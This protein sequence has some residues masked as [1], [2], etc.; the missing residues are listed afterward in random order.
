MATAELADRAEEVAKALFGEPNQRQSTKDELRFGTNGSLRVTI[1]GEHRGTWRDHETGNGGGVL[2]LIVHKQGGDRKSAAAWMREH[3]EGGAQPDRQI[4]ATYRYEDWAGELVHEVVRYA[5]KEFRQRRPDGR[6]GYQWNMKGVAPLLYNLPRV[7]DAVIGGEL[8][9]VVE[10]EKDADRLNA[11]G[12]VATC[13]AGG[14]G[15]W[16]PEHSRQIAGAR[17]AIIPDNDEAGRTHAEQVAVALR[18]GNHDVR[19]VEL[20]VDARKG[21]VSDW[22]DAGGTAAQL[23]ELIEVAPQWRPAFKPRFPLVWFG[24]EDARGP[25]KWLVR[26]LLVTSGLSVFFG[27]PKSTKTFVALDL[28]LH[29]AHG[30][31]W[32][33]MRVQRGG[34]A[35]I[36]GEGQAGV[37]QRMKAWRL[38]R[39]GEPSAPFALIP[40]SVNLFDDLDELDRLIADITGMAEPMGQPV[41]LVVLDTLS[42]MIGG[43]DED[44][45]RDVNVVVRSAERIQ[46]L[47]GAHVLIVHHSGKDRDRG[48]RGSNALLGAVDAAVEVTK[49]ADTGLCEAKVTAIKDGG[50]VGPFAYTLRQTAVGIDDE[51]EPIL[52]CVIDPAGARQGGKRPSLADG[53]RRALAVLRALVGD[54]GDMPGHWQNVPLATWRDT[55]GTKETGEAEAIKRRFNRAKNSLQDKG[56][57]EVRGTDVWLMEVAE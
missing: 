31:D 38:E 25:L 13:N 36:C 26:G 42:R 41:Q 8:V 32:Y 44:K 56:F 4:V 7:H 17:V 9:I 47:T 2:D 12:L 39:D 11:L 22:L 45:A 53:E 52:S 57:I 15:K 34:V 14:A 50:E 54:N 1:A 55:F 21:D 35:Y 29:I 43:G 16:K 5:P 10:G 24:Q 19:L 27:A 23:R 28:A 3:F 6:G 49:D 48:M 37:L 51:G 20:Q 33:G 18:E 30:R 46:R 40:Q